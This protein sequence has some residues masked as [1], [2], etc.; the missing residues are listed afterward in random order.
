MRLKCE[1][2]SLQPPPPSTTPTPT[3]RPPR[4]ARTEPPGTGRQTRK[5]ARNTQ[6][7]D[8]TD[9]PT[10]QTGRRKRRCSLCARDNHNARTCL[11]QR[12]IQANQVQ[13]TSR[14]QQEQEVQQ[15]MQGVG[16]YVS[17]TT[18]NSYYRGSN[19]GMPPQPTP[20]E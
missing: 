18:G 16:V 2:N 1:E 17:P 14:R 19:R 5:S 15:A 8:Q 7:V 13:P 9:L 10:I 4:A 6:Q 20:D 12:G 3:G 11:R